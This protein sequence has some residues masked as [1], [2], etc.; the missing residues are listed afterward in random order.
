[1]KAFSSTIQMVRPPSR[2]RHE[3]PANG[4]Q[5][6]EVKPDSVPFTAVAV[7]S[8][9]LGVNPSLMLDVIGMPERTATR[10]RQEGFLKAEEADR[11]LRVARIFEEAVRV[12]G[13]EEKAG[14]W[15]A[16]VSPMLYGFAPFRLLDSDAGAQAV[17]EELVR[18]DFGDFA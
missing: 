15:L 11:L 12:F 10:R 14:R 13:T 6:I 8:A 5:L 2:S 17:S 9:K 4:P 16:S 18:I 3:R 1:M 7:L